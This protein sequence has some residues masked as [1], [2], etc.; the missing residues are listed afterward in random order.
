MRS[1]SQKDTHININLIQIFIDISL[2]KNGS[3]SPFSLF[4]VQYYFEGGEKDIPFPY[5]YGNSKR[6]EPFK[7]TTYSIRKEIKSVTSKVNKGKE[8]IQCLSQSAG[9]FSKART[10]AELPN[11]LN[12][13]YDLCQKKQ[14]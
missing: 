6:D 14:N 7:A 13:I 5:T 9:G 10:V 8:I 4:Y 1:K 11:S 2:S 12:Q 3:C